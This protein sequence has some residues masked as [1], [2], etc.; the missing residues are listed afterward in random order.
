MGFL[1]IFCG[2]TTRVC[3]SEGLSQYTAL[4]Y[5]AQRRLYE[6]DLNPFVTGCISIN[7]GVCVTERFWMWTCVFVV[8]LYGGWG[9]F[10]AVLKGSV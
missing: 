8:N 2:T 3:Y 6:L 9:A 7:R 1:I 5:V 4:A 10:L